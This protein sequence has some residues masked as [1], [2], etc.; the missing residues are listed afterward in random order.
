MQCWT[1]RLSGGSDTARS[2]MKERLAVARERETRFLMSFDM[3]RVNRRLL[4]LLAVFIALN[5][6]DAFT[7]LVALKAAGFVELNPIA[8]GLF[9]L[10]FGGFVLALALK[11]SPIVPL[12]YAT[13]VGIEGKRPIPIRVVKVS[14]LIVLVAADIFYLGVVG[15]NTLTLAAHFF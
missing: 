10:D 3:D 11:Y 2:S 12:S 7:T 15:A 6:L 14:A 13:L 1:Q 4:V 9:H 8:S 5:F